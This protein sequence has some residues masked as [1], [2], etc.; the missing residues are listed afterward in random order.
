MGIRA[1]DLVVTKRMLQRA[2][3]AGACEDALAV[4]QV[5]QPIDRIPA[6]W[7][8]W[9][10]TILP[11]YEID[12]IA[13]LMSRSDCNSVDAYMLGID[14]DGCGDGYGDGYGDGAGAGA[15]Y[16]YGAGTGAGY[17]YGY[18]DGAGD[19]DGDGDGA[20]YGDG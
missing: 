19:G 8:G 3:I 12:A 1:M 10:T 16:G 9:C 20:G 18:G 6:D 13:S 7:L 2:I 14:G 17:G 15:G 4:I 11:P 5:G